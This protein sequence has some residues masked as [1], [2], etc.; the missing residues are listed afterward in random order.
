MNGLHYSFHYSDSLKLLHIIDNAELSPWTLGDIIC[1]HFYIWK[2]Q[3]SEEH[4]ILQFSTTQ[5]VAQR[6]IGLK[7]L[8]CDLTEYVIWLNH[9]LISGIDYINIT[10]L[11]S[12]DIFSP[13]GFFLFVFCL[14][15]LFIH[16]TCIEFKKKK[17]LWLLSNIDFC[18]YLYVLCHHNKMDY[19]PD[20]Y[21]VLE[22]G[23]KNLS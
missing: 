2:H 17:T 15:V 23:G 12:S 18:W 7:N 20:N 16:V 13:L 3:G 6:T 1:Y 11:W 8:P 21:W 14:F 9:C 4:I 22:L 10:L 5:F 19:S